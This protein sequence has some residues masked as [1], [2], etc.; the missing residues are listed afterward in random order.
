MRDGRRASGPLAA[1]GRA[2]TA[3]DGV[4]PATPFAVRHEGIAYD[5]LRSTLSVAAKLTVEENER[6]RPR[7]ARWKAISRSNVKAPVRFERDYTGRSAER[8]H[9]GA[10]S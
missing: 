2:I 6:V 3:A 7:F 9:A 10:A 4:D 8:I 5:A 1:R